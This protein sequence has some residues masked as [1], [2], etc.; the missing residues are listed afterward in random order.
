M[1]VSSALQR[2]LAALAAVGAICLSYTVQA[3]PTVGDT[4]LATLVSRVYERYAW[5]AVFSVKAPAG[6][7][8]LAQAR[9]KELQEIF[10]PDLARAV[11]NDAQCAAKRRE[12][13]TLDFDLLFDSQDPSASD[14]VVQPGSSDTEVRACFNDAT[15]VQR[16]LIF[17]GA[18]VGGSVKVADIVYSKDRS[19]RQLLGMVKR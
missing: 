4:R 14:L 5:V 18:T 8:P 16:C 1:Q 2:C 10:V 13:C 19:L 7:V 12:I 17:R 6:A 3:A 15:G 11:L 9:Y